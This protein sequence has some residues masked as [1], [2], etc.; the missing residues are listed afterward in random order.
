MGRE[1]EGLSHGM[2]CD[3]RHGVQSAIPGKDAFVYRYG[4][5]YE[6]SPWVA[7]TVWDS[8]Q[9]LDDPIA[10]ADVMQVV[11][12]GAGHMR[13]VTLL[14][15]H[16]DLAGRLG[17]ADLT[18]DSCSEQQGAGLDCCSE[19][20]LT[21]FQ[22]LNETYKDRFGFPFILAVKGHNRTSI[23]DNFRKRVDNDQ[24]TE[25][26][27]ALDQVHRIARFRLQALAEENR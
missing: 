14:R 17:L 12:E 22:H 11:V 5:I 1:C 3:M 2:A 13:Q 26:R 25:F 27:E 15:A 18:V 7:E 4:G 9:A 24:N 6:H 23:L 21:E 20:E 16:P 8:G 19:S 10:L